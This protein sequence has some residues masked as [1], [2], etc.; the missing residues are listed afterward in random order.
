MAKL[1][2]KPAN[3]PL[4]KMLLMGL[5]GQG[6]STS[7]IPL[8]IPDFKGS[9]GYELRV[10]DFDSKFEEVARATLARMLKAGTITQAQHDKALTENIDITVCSEATGIV[11]A[12]EG[13]KTVKKIGVDG[14]ATA[15][16]TAVKQIEKWD[17]SWSDRTI[18]VVDS[19]TYA[20]RA[21]VNW[22]QEL[23][24]KLNQTLEW[25]DY[26]L[27]QQTIESLMIL[28][29]DLPTHCVVTGHQNALEIFKAT[30][31]VDDKGQ[32]VEDLVDVI[33]VPISIGKAGSAK[34]PARF[35][36]M[37]IVTSEG[38]G[39]ATRRWIYTESRVGVVTKTPF[40]G[41]AKERYSIEDGLA[42]YFMLRG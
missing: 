3:A 34:L 4:I 41:L 9:A 7:L 40:H 14:T 30:D 27:P 18:L 22:A 25:R 11:S 20:A 32:P 2:L 1:E 33:M 15:W 36:H 37:L 19:L 21:V 17:R 28:C 5:S 29:A 10:L 12:R 13:K 39:P 38:K 31:Q 8:A 26:Q 23:N 42:P 24:A 16:T 35:N 6:K